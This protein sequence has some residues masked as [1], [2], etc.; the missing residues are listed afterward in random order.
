MRVQF[1]RCRDGIAQN[2]ALKRTFIVYNCPPNFSRYLVGGRGRGVAR[3]WQGDLT[4]P[5]RSR[6]N[7]LPKGKNRNATNQ[8]FYAFDFASTNS[9]NG[10]TSTFFA[11]V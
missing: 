2:N 5:I 8:I 10:T 11:S 1:F 4:R 3:G 6:G 7:F 9:A